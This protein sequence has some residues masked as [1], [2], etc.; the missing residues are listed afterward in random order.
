MFS[1]LVQGLL[2]RGNIA[3]ATLVVQ[4]LHEAAEV[5]IERDMLGESNVA[6]EVTLF[7]EALGDAFEESIF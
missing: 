6:A 4:K 5:P 7:A 2:G 1:E 3:G